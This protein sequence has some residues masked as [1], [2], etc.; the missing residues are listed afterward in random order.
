MEAGECKSKKENKL[1][2]N[3]PPS[4]QTAFGTKC[5][6]II[7]SR[8]IRAQFA[9]LTEAAVHMA[10]EYINSLGCIPSDFASSKK[11]SAAFKSDTLLQTPIAFVYVMCV[12]RNG[13]YRFLLES[14]I[15]RQ[16][17]KNEYHCKTYSSI[18]C[19]SEKNKTDWFSPPKQY[20]LR[21]LDCHMK[22]EVYYN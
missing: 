10:D 17:C 22:K 11:E 21:L 12:A 1:I 16:D 7:L 15:Y 3:L 18:I 6:L 14:R 2:N 13:L 20:F 19:A 5:S 8:S 4:K 9:F